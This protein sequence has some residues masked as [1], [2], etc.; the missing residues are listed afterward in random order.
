VKTVNDK[1]AFGGSS[2]LVET[3]GGGRP[4][5]RRNLAEAHQALQN[6][7]FQSIFAYSR[8]T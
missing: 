4:F 2:I 8:N 5:V 1:I 3:I 6:A 7:D